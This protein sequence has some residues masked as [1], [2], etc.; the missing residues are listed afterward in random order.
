MQSAAGEALIEEPVALET[1]APVEAV[2]TL[3]TE[4]PVAAAVEDAVAQETEAPVAA[5]VEATIEDVADPESEI[6][7]AAAVEAP[8]EDAAA[9]DTE[10]P[11]DDAAIQDTEELSDDFVNTDELIEEV[12]LSPETALG[13]EDYKFAVFEMYMTVIPEGDE[14]GPVFGYM[15]C[16]MYEIERTAEKETVTLPEK[17]VFLQLTDAHGQKETVYSTMPAL[18]VEINGS[19]LRLPALYILIEWQGQ[20][21]YVETKPWSM[22][23]CTQEDIDMDWVT[24]ASLSDLHAKGG[25]PTDTLGESASDGNSSYDHPV[26]SFL[27]TIKDKV[28]ETIKD[29]VSGQGGT[30]V[31]KK[32]TPKVSLNLTGTL[33]TV[34]GKTCRLKASGLIKGDSVLSWR[35]SNSSVVRV[36]ASGVLTTKKSGSA[37][38][39]VTTRKGAKAS[40][41]VQ[42]T[43]P[44]IRTNMRKVT[45]SLK[46]KK[47]FRLLVSGLLF[48]D[49]TASFTSSNPA[50]ARVSR[51]GLIRAVKKGK[52]QIIVRSKYGA[53]TSVNVTVKKK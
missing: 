38:I 6:T 20:E 11:A 19:Y 27:K 25:N 47:T 34:P 53:V 52:T 28:T 43:Y 2:F 18:E 21:Y 45:L 51:K 15:N 4:A 44:V 50:V 26:I 36:N 39:T 29:A 8:A 22:E 33:R 32:V 5:L 9:P 41:T 24:V 40:L 12:T 37:R 35:S 49:K 23:M 16:G 14:G 13:Y 3:E 42:V 31:V 48:G 46:R 1:E 10:S 7:V 17:S 30:T